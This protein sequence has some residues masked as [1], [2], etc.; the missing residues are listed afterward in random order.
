MAIR[1]DQR[2]ACCLRGLCAYEPP[3]GCGGKNSGAMDGALYADATNKPASGPCFG[4]RP[5]A[6]RALG[7]ST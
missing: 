7:G 3:H 4:C 6:G 2:S 1:E 5:L